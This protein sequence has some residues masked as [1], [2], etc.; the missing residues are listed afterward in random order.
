MTLVSEGLYA[1]RHRPANVWAVGAAGRAAML[2]KL[3]QLRAKT[4]TAPMSNGVAASASPL[5]KA[6]AHL[7]AMHLNEKQTVTGSCSGPALPASLSCVLSPTR[8]EER[9]IPR[10]Q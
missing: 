9:P 7:D 10:P 6:I 5:D 2:E 1:E 8:P 4:P 3:M